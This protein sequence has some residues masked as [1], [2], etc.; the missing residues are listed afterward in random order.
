MQL[1]CEF[2]H[3]HYQRNTVIK[4]SNYPNI[5]LCSRNLSMGVLTHI[6]YDSRP[7]HRFQP[8]TAWTD[9]TPPT[10]VLREGPLH[11]EVMLRPHVAIAQAWLRGAYRFH[12]ERSATNQF[13][14]PTPPTPPPTCDPR[15]LNVAVFVAMPSRRKFARPVSGSPPHPAIES[16]LSFDEGHLVMGVTS[17]PYH[18]Q[19]ICT[20]PKE[21]ER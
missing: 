2:S 17:L 16:G 1:A 21:H 5:Y 7:F 4:R 13:A 3:A 15:M 18:E 12:P 10:G 8:L 14:P 9:D 19:A 6:R 11:T 20:A